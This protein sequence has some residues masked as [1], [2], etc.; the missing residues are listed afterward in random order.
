MFLKIFGSKVMAS[1]LLFVDKIEIWKV[2]S[3]LMDRMAK[4]NNY[5]GKCKEI[6]S[7]SFPKMPAFYLENMLFS[8]LGHSL[9][10]LLCFVCS[11]FVCMCLCSSLCCFL[12]VYCLFIVCVRLWYNYWWQASQLS[13]F[14]ESWKIFILTSKNMYVDSCLPCVNKITNFACYFHLFCVW[15]FCLW[16]AINSLIVSRK[17]LKWT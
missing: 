17:S 4:L 13:R 9:T 6:L 1:T 10:P 16:I 3:N 15:L 5:F 11:C 14:A 7:G 8:S 2:I 12:F